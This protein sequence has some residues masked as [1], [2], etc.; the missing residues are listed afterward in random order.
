[1][2]DLIKELEVAGKQPAGSVRT[3]PG[4]KIIAELKRLGQEI[5]RLQAELEQAQNNLPALQERLQ[6]R[7]G[8]LQAECEKYVT[9]NIVLAEK[10]EQGDYIPGQDRSGKSGGFESE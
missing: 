9:D 6:I 10:A 1:M 3:V 4:H 2:S 8:E 7:N 5:K